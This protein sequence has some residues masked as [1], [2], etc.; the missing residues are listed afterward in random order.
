MGT[1][2]ATIPA[3]L[4]AKYPDIVSEF[5]GGK[6]RTFGGRHVYCFNSPRMYE[7]SEK[8]IR[9]LV[10]HYKEETSIVAWQ[11]DNEIGHEAV[12][13]VIVKTVRKNSRAIFLKNLQEILTG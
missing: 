8:I 9:K 4:A 11:I 6:K 10:E 13:Y 12:M 2:T 7:Y 5:E 3:W 1:P